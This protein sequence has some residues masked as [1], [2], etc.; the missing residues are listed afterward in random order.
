MNGAVRALPVTALP[1]CIALLLL[2]GGCAGLPKLDSR[3]ASTALTDTAETRLGNC[4]QKPRLIRTGAVSIRCRSHRK[5][6]RRASCS[7][8]AAERR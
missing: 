7:A 1:G 8:R 3:T 6:S 2:L 4:R 5:I